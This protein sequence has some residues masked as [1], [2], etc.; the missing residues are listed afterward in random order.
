MIPGAASAQPA[1]GM[2]P[3]PNPGS[4]AGDRTTADIIVETL[5]TW[6]V[7]VILR[8]VGDEIGPLIE[9]ISVRQDKIYYVGVRHKEAAAFMAADTPSIPDDWLPASPPPAPAPS[10]L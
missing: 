8:M 9:A 1:A 3:Q 6:G 2:Q 5:I 7:P 10:I 4:I